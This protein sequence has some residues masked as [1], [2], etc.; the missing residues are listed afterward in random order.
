M[1]RLFRGWSWE[2]WYNLA[3][4]D[5]EEAFDAVRRAARMALYAGVALWVLSGLHIVKQD[6]QGITYVCGRMS[7][8]VEK[9]GLRYRLPW[10]MGAVIKVPVERQQRVEV[11]VPAGGLTAATRRGDLKVGALDRTVA[12]QFE[13]DVDTKGSALDDAIRTGAQSQIG[14]DMALGLG[15]GLAVLTADHNV[16]LIQA[17]V[18]YYV[19]DPKA[20]LTRTEGAELILKRATVAALIESAAGM[21]VD[22]V[23]TERRLELQSAVRERVNSMTK[24]LGLGLEVA[25]VELLRLAAPDPVAQAFRAVNTAREE[26]ETIR[27]EATQYAKTVVP[28]ADGE[29]A[30][31]LAEA[32]SYKSARLAETRGEAS[33]FAGVLKEQQRNGSLTGERLRL[34][35]IEKVLAKAKKVQV[36]G[37]PSSGLD[38]NVIPPAPG[39]GP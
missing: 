36:G 20:F 22:E 17:V 38:V 39:N 5:I 35:T 11:G 13:Q 27:N 10:P 37:S 33:R 4:E 21:S 12:D 32:E 3:R 34:E 1:K 30:K 23:L 6:E 31:I 16:L 8:G 18:Q 25:G 28:Q 15:Q 19:R 26:M 29:A 14:Q 24:P 7:S 9:P 2:Y